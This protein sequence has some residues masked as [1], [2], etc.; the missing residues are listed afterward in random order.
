MELGV[1]AL[2]LI[3]IT[4]FAA[5]VNGALGYGFSSLTVPVALLFYANRILNPALVLI[6]VFVNLYVLIMNRASIPAVWGRVAPIVFSLLPGVA[7]GSYMVASIHPG[8]M[9]FATYAFIL[10]LILIQAAGL[11]RP[12]RSERLFGVPFGVGLGFL[13]S[14]TTISGP[15]IA[16]LFNNQGLVKR[17]FRAGLAV[18]RVAESSLTAFAYYHLGLFA[19]ESFSLIGLILPGLLIGIPLGAYFIRH[20]DAET[21]RRICMSFD[22]WIVGFGLS[23]VLIE[24]KLLQGITGYTPM[25]AAIILDTILLVMFFKKRQS[26]QAAAPASEALLAQKLS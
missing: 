1:G 17:D 10:P 21:F 3:A 22:V 4:F 14:V 13:Y 11:R 9:K 15:P 19:A 20:V 6:E 18:I 2:A 25:M 5:F 23:R 8:W 16:L 26:S 7:V 24:L 12:I